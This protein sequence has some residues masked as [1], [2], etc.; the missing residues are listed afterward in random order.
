MLSSREEKGEQL[1]TGCPENLGDVLSTKHDSDIPATDVSNYLHAAEKITAVL[2]TDQH[3]GSTNSIASSLVAFRS[4]VYAEVQRMFVHNSKY[5]LL[6][7]R[8]FKMTSI[9]LTGGSKEPDS[10]NVPWIASIIVIR[11]LGAY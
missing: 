9:L 10:R 4:V 2:E 5:M 3:G 8:S 1:G 11:R 7:C 6:D